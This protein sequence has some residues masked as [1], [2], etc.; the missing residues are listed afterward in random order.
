MESHNNLF[1]S[2]CSLENLRI[3]W[4]KAREGKTLH[5]NIIEFEKDLDNNILTLYV[6]LKKKTYKPKPLQNFILRDPKTRKISK[7]D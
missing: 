1:N 6:E 7:S 4:S 2:L 5:E 3:A